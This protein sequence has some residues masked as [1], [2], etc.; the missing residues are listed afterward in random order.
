M[1]TMPDL[2]HGFSH[3]DGIKFGKGTGIK[4]YIQYFY[5]KDEGNA[6]KQLTAA[7][8][9]ERSHACDEQ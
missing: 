3:I 8:K 1:A 7:W 6:T 9:L 5:M 2:M 4:Y